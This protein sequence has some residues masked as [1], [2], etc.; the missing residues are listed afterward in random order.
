MKRTRELLHKAAE[1]LPHC[2][3]AAALNQLRCQHGEAN[4]AMQ[5]H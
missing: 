5:T 2:V 1:T 4:S 3:A